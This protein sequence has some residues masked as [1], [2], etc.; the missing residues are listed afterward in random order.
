ML[1]HLI[2]LVPRADDVIE[3][4]PLLPAGAWPYFCADG[5]PYHGRNLTI[6]WDA[7]GNFIDD[8]TLSVH[9]SRLREKIG[10][11]HII[12]VR[13]FGYRWEA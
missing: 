2:G 9:I 3:I 12:T 6:I 4:D 5:I 8:N 13:G 11:A 1:H 10:A 7:D